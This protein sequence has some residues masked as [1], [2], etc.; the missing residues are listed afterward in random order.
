M[1]GEI[2]WTCSGTSYVFRLKFY[3]DCNG[4]DGPSSTPLS[5]NVPGVPQIPM[6]LLTQTDISPDGALNSG[7]TQCVNCPPPVGNGSG[8]VGAVEEFIFQSAPVVL[9]GTPPAGGWAF[10]WGDCCRSG[11]LNNI[12]NPGS[13]GFGLRAK[14][15]P[16][17]GFTAG[18][19]HD[20][21]PYFA[22][23][24]ST[25]ICTGYNFT[26]NPNA[27]D[28]ELDSIVYSWDYPIDDVSYP[29]TPYIQYSAPYSVNNQIPGTPTLNSQSG[30]INYN[31]L[32][33]G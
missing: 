17:P 21:S 13:I 1:G 26:Y 20:N 25:I 3:R 33:G 31:P 23:K 4:I 12:A 11:S 2:T 5:T 19:C 22:E 28:Q 29:W 10:W 18:Q 14:M 15:Y 32:T 8:G 7:N 6:A 9:P 24:P 16:Y 27:V 30:E